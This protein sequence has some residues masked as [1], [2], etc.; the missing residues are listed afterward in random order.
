MIFEIQSLSVDH[1]PDQQTITTTGSLRIHGSAGQVIPGDPLY[2]YGSDITSVNKI[3]NETGNEWLS[4]KLNIREAQV[5]W[6]IREEM[7]RTVEDI[8]SRR[9]RALLLDAGESI[10]IAPVVAGIMA[11][12]MNRDSNW[13][14]AQVKSYNEVAKNYV[15]ST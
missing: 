6:G 11:Q 3:I 1:S 9:T 14:E 13:T 5:L 15:I 12:E 10:A 8:L 7:A 4:K 2:Y